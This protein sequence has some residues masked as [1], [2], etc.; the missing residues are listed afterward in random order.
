MILDLPKVTVEQYELRKQDF[1]KKPNKPEI[2]EQLEDLQRK[3]LIDQDYSIL[4]EIQEKLAIYAKSLLLQSLK[5]STDYI[6]PF[7][8]EELAELAA[9]YFIKRYF[10]VPDPVVGA[11]F[12]GILQ[13]KVKEVLST[14]FKGTAVES[15]VSLDTEL[16]SSKS[17]SENRTVEQLLTFKM[18]QNEHGEDEDLDFEDHVEILEN[19]ISKECEMLK[20][21]P[22][23]RNLNLKFLQYLI[24]VYLLQS[25]RLDRRLLNVS[26]Q[27]LRFISSNEESYQ[28]LT[29]IMESAFL[30]VAEKGF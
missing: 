24:Y 12:A 3:L 6:E 21:I 9:E 10:R 29:P 26:N 19:R 20:V 17:D 15:N 23:E 11:S 18:Y 14:Y 7:K 1:Y 25:T 16:T 28:K 27:A 13:F 2:E 4:P 5:G 30:D 22:V 8:V